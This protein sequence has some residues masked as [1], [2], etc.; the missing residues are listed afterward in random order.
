MEV[1]IQKRQ[2]DIFLDH[3]QNSTSEESSQRFFAISRLY[4]ANAKFTQEKPD[5]FCLY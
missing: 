1:F 3:P 5:I 2:Y 4:V